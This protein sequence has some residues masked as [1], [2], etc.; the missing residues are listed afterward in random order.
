MPLM[1]IVFG[2][3]SDLFVYQEV[4]ETWLDIYWDNITM[5]YPNASKADLI[6]N[7]NKVV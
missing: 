4:Y 1:I 5:Y 6:D 2:N 7:P 3:M